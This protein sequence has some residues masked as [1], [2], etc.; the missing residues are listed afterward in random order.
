M[1]AIASLGNRKRALP[2][3]EI[4]PTRLL[5]YINMHSKDPIAT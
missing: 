3:I 5:K 1:R 2:G 4:P